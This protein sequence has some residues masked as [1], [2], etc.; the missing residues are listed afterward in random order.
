MALAP[1]AA[2]PMPPAGGAPSDETLGVD[3]G[4]TDEGMEPP[5]LFTV[6]GNMGGPYTLM[7]GD[8]PE[9]DAGMPP[10]E[11]GAPAGGDMPAAAEGK[12]FDTPQALL[13]GVMELLNDSGG[14][15]K[16]F[17]GGFKGEPD[18]PMA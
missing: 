9:G 14:A 12:T 7:P 17:A 16:A 13:R 8:E 10:G 18:A 3:A 4:A 11:A 1:T 5:V 15:E 6:T 2:P